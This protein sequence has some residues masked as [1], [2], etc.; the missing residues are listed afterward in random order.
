MINLN[1]IFELSLNYMIKYI[2]LIYLYYSICTIVYMY[3][4]LIYTKLQNI[5]IRMYDISTYKAS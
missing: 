5:R 3:N 4:Y 2:D 1:K